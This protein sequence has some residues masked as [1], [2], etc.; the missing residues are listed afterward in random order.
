M[1]D[2]APQPKRMGRPPKHPDQGKRP[3]LSLRVS[4]ALYDQI[5]AAAAE[6]GRSLS[7]EM[8]AR[9]TDAFNQSQPEAVEKAEAAARAALD[10]EYVEFFGGRNLMMIAFS[11]GELFK[12]SLAATY[13]EWNTEN[14]EAITDAFVAA[15]LDKVVAG[16]RKIINEWYDRV[17]LGRLLQTADLDRFFN[18]MTALLDTPQGKPL[19][20]ALYDKIG[21]LSSRQKQKPDR[22]GDDGQA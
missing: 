17:K 21:G 14:P 16:Q 1:T 4:Q 12:E 3:S 18:D 6:N 7:E 22:G 5:A 13:A 11:E 15:L 2:E 19:R 10:E 9:V 20:D 8:E